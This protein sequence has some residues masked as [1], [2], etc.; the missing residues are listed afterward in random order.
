MKKTET[1]IDGLFTL[2]ATPFTDNR[3][4]FQRLYCQDTLSEF[5]VNESINQINHSYTKTKG[6]IRGLHFQHPPFSETKV[7]SCLAGGI[8]DVIVDLRTN[9]ATF[10]KHVHIE[11]TESD[12]TSIVIPHGCAHGFQTLNNDTQLLY[13]HTENYAPKY[14]GGINPL[15]PTLAIAWPLAVS[16]ISKKDSL[17]QNIDQDFLGLTI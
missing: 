2:E 11:L 1:L 9:S 8:H 5:G 15:D 13:L 4:Y 12:S 6:S 3:G 16:N 17:L 10:L 14:E 7:I